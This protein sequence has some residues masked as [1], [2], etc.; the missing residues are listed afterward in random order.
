MEAPIKEALAKDARVSACRNN[1][2]SSGFQEDQ[3]LLVVTSVPAVIAHLAE[4]QWQG[5]AYARP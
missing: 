4:R 3:L 1:M 5:W 2:R